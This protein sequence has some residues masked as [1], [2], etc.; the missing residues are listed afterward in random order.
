MQMREM[1][2]MMAE[3]VKNAVREQV[4]EEVQA[5]LTQ[6]LLPESQKAAVQ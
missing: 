2:S 5:T 6:H 4:R 1:M 3:N